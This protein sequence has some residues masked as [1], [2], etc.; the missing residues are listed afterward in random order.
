MREHSAFVVALLWMALSILIHQHL[1]G[2]VPYE[3]ISGMVWGAGMALYSHSVVRK[4]FPPTKE[5]D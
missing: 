4:M 3:R 5:A 1:Y 2:P